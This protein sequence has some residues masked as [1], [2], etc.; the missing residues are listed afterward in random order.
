MNEYLPKVFNRIRSNW[1]SRPINP[2]AAIIA[3]ASSVFIALVTMVYWNN[4]FAIAEKLE[5]S[6]QLV[7]SNHEYYRLWTAS[8][9]HADLKHLLSNLF[10]FFILGWF[11]SGYFGFFLFPLSAFFMG[12]VLNALILPSYAPTTT[13]LG[14]SGIVFYLGGVWLSLYFFIQRQQSFF[15]RFLRIGGVTLA[16]FMPSEAF[17]PSIS[18][19]THF[20][21]LALGAVVGSVYFLFKKNQIR[22]A[23]VREYIVEEPEE[24]DIAAQGN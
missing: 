1:L 6:K 8:L 22:R 7:F 16:L 23:E 12:G 20:L 24:L 9:I 3:G 21:G 5:A 15:Q 14:A 11:L 4:D 17:D 19:R 2:N 18:Y 13:L 10:M